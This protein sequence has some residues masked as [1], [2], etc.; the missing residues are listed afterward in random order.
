MLL[1][2]YYEIKMFHIKLHNVLGYGFIKL[3]KR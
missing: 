1:K 3:L 2:V